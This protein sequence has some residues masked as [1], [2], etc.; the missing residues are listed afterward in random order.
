MLGIEQRNVPACMLS[1]GIVSLVPFFSIPM[2]Y[3]LIE[4]PRLGYQTLHHFEWSIGLRVPVTAERKT[5]T[6]VG[7]GGDDEGRKA[8][9]VEQNSLG[10]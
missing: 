7:N 4:A 5:L 10:K 1:H 6:N 3:G 2:C 8:V 9:G